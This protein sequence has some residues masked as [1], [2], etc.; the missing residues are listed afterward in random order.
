LNIGKS[1]LQLEL[2]SAQCYSTGWFTIQTA[3]APVRTV[4]ATYATVLS[5]ASAASRPHHLPPGLHAQRMHPPPRA[6]Y[7]LLQSIDDSKSSSHLHLPRL[8]TFTATPPSTEHSI[9]SDG[10]T[11][12][13]AMSCLPLSCDIVDHCHLPI[14]KSC[15]PLATSPSP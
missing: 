15:S 4:A 5:T 13:P 11:A 12:P 8:C 6:P 7:P 2:G 10:T 14:T 3:L 9:L 1:I